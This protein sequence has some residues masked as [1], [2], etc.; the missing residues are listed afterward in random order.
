MG[1]KSCHLIQY[2]GDVVNPIEDTVGNLSCWQTGFH[3]F[4]DTQNS[5]CILSTVDKKGGA[6]RLL[7]YESKEILRKHQISTPDG[8]LL[9]PKDQIDVDRPVVLK[10]Q[11]PSGGRGKA[12]GV[13]ESVTSDQA[14]SQIKALFSRR[15]R[16]YRV[17]KVLVENRVQAEQ[18]F[19]MAV[20]YDTLA[21]APLA[22]FSAKGGV[23]I[24]ELAIQEPEAVR[25]ETF[26]VRSGLPRYRARDIIAESGISG[27][28]L[29]DLS[30]ILSK[31]ADIFITYDATLAEIN[32]LA[33]T[34]EGELIALDCHLDIDEDALFRQR[35]IAEIKQDETRVEST[36]RIS[37]F[38]RNAAAIDNLDH[39]GVAGRVIEFEGD[40]GLII[41]G[42][43]ASLTAFDAIRAHGGKPANYCEIGGNP[44]VLKVKELTRL[45]LSKPNVKKIAVIMNV[46][47]NTRVDMV[48][49]GIVKGTLESGK[50]PSETIAAFRI[51][52]AWEEEGAKILSKYGVSFLDRTVSID[53]AARLAVEKMKIQSP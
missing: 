10:A 18:E 36:K 40:M 31:L 7:E 15:L 20:T 38:E 33:L 8:K 26:S 6:V 49:R 52:G 41:G 24:E 50:K 29:L 42:G 47:S 25:M 51:P 11:I 1:Q 22:I 28:L 53:E 16:G 39:R 44:S 45:I 21:K 46:V 23:D 13:L 43:G 14:N 37:K 19:F 3:F 12:G 30:G 34:V 17:N 9:T 4:L 48:A 5:I 32:P 35:A 2:G 27:K